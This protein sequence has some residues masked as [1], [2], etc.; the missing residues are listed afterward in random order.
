MGRKTELSALSP[1]RSVF[2]D[3]FWA[4]STVFLFGFAHLRSSRMIWRWPELSR[5]AIFGKGGT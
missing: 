1:A 5:N 2:T 3:I 4:A